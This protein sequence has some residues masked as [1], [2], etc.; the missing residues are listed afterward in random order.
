MD[1]P[2]VIHKLWEWFEIGFA[3]VML[4]TMLLKTLVWGVKDTWRDWH[5]REEDE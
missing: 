4:L 1:Y 2:P 5:R 3:G